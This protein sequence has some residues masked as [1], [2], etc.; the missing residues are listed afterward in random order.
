MT[1]QGVVS[2]LTLVVESVHEQRLVDGLLRC[3]AR[4]WT[5]TP[6]R[7]HGPG[8]TGMTEV[9]GGSSRIEVLTSPEVAGRIWELL[10]S[11]FFPHYSMAAWEY[12][13]SVARVERYVG[14]TD[15]SG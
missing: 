13:V 8:H 9:E 7:G 15:A 10:R 12:P 14:G 5:I 3:G 4:G 11:D 2:C 1:H 6:A